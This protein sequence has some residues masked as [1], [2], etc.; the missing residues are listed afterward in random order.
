MALE[1]S[2][3]ST[4]LTM[5]NDSAITFKC[6]KREGVCCNQDARNGCD[7]WAM[8]RYTLVGL[9]QPKKG[10]E[11]LRSLL[12]DFFG[13]KTAQFADLARS[14]DDEC[15]FVALAA[16]RRRREIR[17]IGLD[18]HA[19]ERHDGGRVANVLRLGKGDVAGE[20]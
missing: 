4:L 9:R 3:R 13:R 19:V 2:C 14:L 6:N 8:D 12:A 15:G 7:E 18:E 17:R 20:G 10:G 16:M 1:T 5:S 11:I